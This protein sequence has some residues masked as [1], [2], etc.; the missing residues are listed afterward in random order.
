MR[1]LV[2]ALLLVAACTGGERSP[3]VR[4]TAHDG[5]V[6]YARMD[7]ALHSQAGGFLT[8]RDLVTKETVRL[9]NGTYVAEEVPPSEI[10]IRQ[11][12]YLDDPTRKPVAS[13][14]EPERR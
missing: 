4:V 7:R 6:Y 9:K 2:P 14:H 13:D 11:Q 3:F 10:A 8:F 5:R 12:E 1:A